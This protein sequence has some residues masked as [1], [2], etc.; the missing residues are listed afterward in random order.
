M[1]ANSNW[2]LRDLAKALSYDASALTR[3]MSPSRCIPQA[4]EAFR[5]GKIVFG[6]TYA[7]SKAETPEEQLSLL[8]FCLSGA[9]RDAAEKA[10]RK[11]RGNGTASAAD[12]KKVNRIKCMVNGGVVQ[13]SGDKLGMTELITL[14]AD[15]LKAAERGH[16]DGMD[17]RA[18]QAVLKSKNKAKAG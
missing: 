18:F 15:L 12:A 16:K 6:H 5:E 1:K 10:V 13:V 11:N 17:V 9:S 4:V 7:I 14:L 3:I 8:N 2:Q